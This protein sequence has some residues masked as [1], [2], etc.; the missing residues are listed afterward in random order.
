MIVMT[1]KFIEH[2]CWIFIIPL[3]VRIP[4]THFTLQVASSIHA[5]NSSCGIINHLT[6]LRMF[7]CITICVVYDRLVIIRF[8][9]I[10]SEL[11]SKTNTG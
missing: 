1:I 8:N 3:Y 9:E 6:L 10:R 7:H 5:C 2:Y 4:P 11:N